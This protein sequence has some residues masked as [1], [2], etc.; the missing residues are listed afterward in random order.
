MTKNSKKRTVLS[1]EEKL[2]KVQQGLFILQARKIGMSS[3]DIR[4]I[5]C[6]DKAEVNSIAKKVNKALKATDDHDE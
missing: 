6:C 3:D 4:E 2:Y 5:L 1:L